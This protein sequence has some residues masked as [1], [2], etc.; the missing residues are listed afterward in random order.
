MAEIRIIGTSHIS[1][2]SVT[3]V[4]R[5]IK[6]LQPDFVA[7]ELDPKRLTALLSKQKGR[8]PMLMMIKRV[9][10]QGYLFSL[11]GAWIENKLGKAVGVSPG[12]EMLSAIKEAK[13][14]NA[15]IALIDQDIEI[16]LR[17]FSKRFTWKEKLRLVWDIIVGVFKKDSIMK[18][19]LTK[20]PSKNV[21]EQMM[22][23]VKKRYPNLYY[24][25]VESRN[26][27]M[28]K[29]L[30]NL[31]TKFPDSKIVAVV[32]AGHEEG[33]KKIIQ[34]YIDKDRV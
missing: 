6:E 22:Q 32:G 10:V 3:Q 2:H 26:K 20:V 4:K 19:D 33:M 17:Q 1:S 24:V 23:M 29:R 31:M 13:K 14:I 11:I 5:A 34:N 27:Y 8:P 12:T 28:A 30:I 7:V 16:T 18:F 25:L 15:K 21:I 9:G